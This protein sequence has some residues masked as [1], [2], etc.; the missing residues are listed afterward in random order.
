MAISPLQRVYLKQKAYHQSYFNDITTQGLPD[1][2]VV[3][4]QKGNETLLLIEGKSMMDIKNGIE[5]EG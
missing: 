4:A 5:G 2:T 1:V 3:D